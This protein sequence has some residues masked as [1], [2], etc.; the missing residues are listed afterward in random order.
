MIAVFILICPILLAVF[1]ELLESYYDKKH[2]TKK[3]NTKKHTTKKVEKVVEDWEQLLFHKI[4][5]KEDLTHKELQCIERLLYM[6]AIYEHLLS[7]Q[8]GACEN[9]AG[10]EYVKRCK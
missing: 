7:I 3:C 5:N 4:K 9:D 1:I 10:L 8:A 2:S 6:H